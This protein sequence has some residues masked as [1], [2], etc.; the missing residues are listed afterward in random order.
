MGSGQ[1]GVRC[2]PLGKQPHGTELAPPRQAGS[3]DILCYHIISYHIIPYDII[4]SHLTLH[5]MLIS[6]HFMCIHEQACCE[7]LLQGRLEYSGQAWLDFEERALQRCGAWRG[8]EVV[9][10]H[11]RTREC[12]AP[13]PHNREHASTLLSGRRVYAK[14]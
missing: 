1:V 13:Q 9:Q 14:V 11:R 7:S 8:P 10:V 4:L 2:Q 6:Y 5:C 3:A 12:L